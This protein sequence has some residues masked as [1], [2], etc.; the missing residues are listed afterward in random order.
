VLFVVTLFVGSLIVTL[1]A[2]A[3]FTRRLEAVS[4]LWELSPGLLSLLGALGANIP[5]Y[6]AALDAAWSGQTG[7]GVGIIVGSNIFNIAIILGMVTFAT[8]GHHGIS[9]SEQ[10]A[11]DAR[12]VGLPTLLMMGTTAISA[13]LAWFI[14]LNQSSHPGFQSLLLIGLNVLSL[15]LF[16]L[17]IRHA[18]LHNAEQHELAEKMASE[19]EEANLQVEASVSTPNRRHW[20]IIRVLGEIVCALG[21]ALGG[22][23]VMVQSGEAIARQ[24]HLP[25]A[26]LSLLILAV[27]TSL[28]NMVVAFLLARTGRASASVEEIFSSNSVNATLGM[29]LPLLFWPLLSSDMLIIS[30]D[31][32]LMV[33]LTL[34]ALLCVRH[35]RISKPVAA[36]L[37]L[38]YAVFVAL[39][40]LLP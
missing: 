22:V 17:L 1:S 21:I 33:V 16:G 38:T 15:G 18:L 37:V 40:L 8:P 19:S 9:L 4:D 36:L 34:L 7:V 30:L 25:D 11:H 3:F 12:Q 6:A 32:P 5:N 27:A 31:A 35:R 13:A 29:A 28:P 2:S 14:T 39:H 10:E 20:L 26:I 24:L 23:V